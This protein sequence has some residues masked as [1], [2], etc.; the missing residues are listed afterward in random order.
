MVSHIE[1]GDKELKKP[2]MFTEFGLS[3]MNKDFTPTQRERFYRVILDIVYK[4]AIRSK[5]GAGSLVW[6]FLVEGMEEFDDDFG[7]V[8]WK[9][10]STYKLFTEQSCKLARLQG[11]LPSQMDYLR[12]LCR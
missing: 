2:V 3:A 1:D 10:P 5:S 9:S 12:R 6:Q 11:A 8:P 7:I 4:S